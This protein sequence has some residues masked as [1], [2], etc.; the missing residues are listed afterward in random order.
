[1]LTL[2]SMTKIWN[3]AFWKAAPSP[4]EDETMKA[5]APKEDRRPGSIKSMM[6]PVMALA[7]LTLVIGLFT[8]PFY[9][10]ALRAADQLLDREGYVAAVMG[11][12]R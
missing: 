10:L 11:A 8:A 3:E 2:F 4:D 7:G 12:Q 5:H 9:D 1:M 6:A